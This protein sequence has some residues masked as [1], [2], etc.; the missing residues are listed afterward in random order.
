MNLIT[1]I[2]KGENYDYDGFLG[3]EGVACAGCTRK[4]H[5][6]LTWI[7][8]RLST[9][10]SYL[11]FQFTSYEWLSNKFSDFTERF[12]EKCDFC[13]RSNILHPTNHHSFYGLDK[14]DDRYAKKWCQGCWNERVGEGG[15]GF[16]VNFK[17]GHDSEC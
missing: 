8:C 12:T 13:T 6:P 2:I 9:I 5:N 14:D 1:K 3:V 11:Y 16:D 7:A 15:C 4:T 10:D 17:A